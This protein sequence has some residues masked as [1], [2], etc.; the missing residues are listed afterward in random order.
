MIYPIYG[1]SNHQ[2]LIPD[3]RKNLLHSAKHDYPQQKEQDGF[4]NLCYIFFITIHKLS[5]RPPMPDP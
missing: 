4:D 3:W 5:R 1:A 2:T